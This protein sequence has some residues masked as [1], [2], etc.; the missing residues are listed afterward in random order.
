[1][2]KTHI[3]LADIFA[4][5]KRIASTIQHTAMVQSPSLTQMSGH[6]VYLKLEHRQTT[7]TAGGECCKKWCCGCF[8]G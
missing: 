2:S 6:P 3:G 8:N 4:A 7:G 5:R 1:M